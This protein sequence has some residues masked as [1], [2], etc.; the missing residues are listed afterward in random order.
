MF[1]FLMSNN[2]KSKKCESVGRRITEE[3][4]GDV[5]TLYFTKGQFKEHDFIGISKN[6]IELIIGD[7][8]CYRDP[9]HP[10]YH[11]MSEGRIYPDYQLDYKKLEWITDLAKEAEGK[12]III[13]HF[14]DV[15]MVWDLNKTN[16]KDRVRWKMCN[17]TG[18]NYGKEKEESKQSY[19]EFEEAVYIKDNKT[20]KVYK[21]YKDWMK[22]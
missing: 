2:E 15:T 6:G 8:K 9:E 11:N 22:E 20:G 13:V 5:F 14:T 17:K 18:V 7:I 3:M 12:P 19:L 10:R 16:W 1:N 21:S 4:F